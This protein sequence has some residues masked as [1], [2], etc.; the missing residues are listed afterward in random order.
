GAER[1]PVA[2][3]TSGFVLSIPVFFDTVFYL[4]IPIARS[5]GA[6]TKRNYVFYVMAICAGA[7]ATHALV[8]PTPGPLYVANAFNIDLGLMI[9]MGLVMAAPAAL[10]GLAFSAFMSRRLDI[11]MRATA[12]DGVLE[13]LGDERLPSLTLSLAPVVL[14]VILISGN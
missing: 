1:A 9:G 3:T 6:R 12:D 14:P 5:L 4:L 10:V 8:P 11:P 2:L 13:P 7:A